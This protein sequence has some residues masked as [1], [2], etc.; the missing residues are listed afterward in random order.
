MAEDES[1]GSVQSLRLTVDQQAALNNDSYWLRMTAEQEQLVKT[2]GADETCIFYGDA[3][4]RLSK[5]KL[6][7]MVEQAVKSAIRSALEIL[8]TEKFAEFELDPM[9]LGC[10]FMRVTVTDTDGKTASAIG[11]LPDPRT[12]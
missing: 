11:A 5:T 10:T 8:G 3:L 12:H 2:V 1:T 6:V 4:I 7:A 9:T